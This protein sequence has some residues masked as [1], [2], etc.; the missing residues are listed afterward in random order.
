MRRLLILT[1]L[2]V[3]AALI[4]GFVVVRFGPGLAHDDG[5]AAAIGGPFTL[6]DGAG[7]TVTQ[8]DF[9]GR[10]ML[11]YFGYTHCPDACPMTLN[12][13]ALALAKLPA[14]ARAKIAPV[15]ITVDPARDTPALMQSYARAFD[16]QITGLSGT[17]SQVTSAEQEYHVYAQRHEIKGA[18]AGDYEMDHSSVVYVMKPDGS[19]ATVLDDAMPPEEMAHRLVALEG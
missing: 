13:I 11:V 7:R 15:F 17:V 8:R 3:V 18:A 5:G 16:P 10:W 2:P 14:A 1:A 9:R 4:L 19:F 12:A 6:T